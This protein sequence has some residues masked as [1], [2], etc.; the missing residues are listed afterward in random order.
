MA[1]EGERCADTTVALN[2]FERH[3]HYYYYC[4]SLP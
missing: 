4:T 1:T 2:N 3:G